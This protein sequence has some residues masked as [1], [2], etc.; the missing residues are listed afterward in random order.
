MNGSSDILLFTRPLFRYRAKVYL[1]LIALL[2]RNIVPWVNPDPKGSPGDFQAQNAP[3]RLLPAALGRWDE[4]TQPKLKMPYE[5]GPPT[6]VTEAL[7]QTLHGTVFTFF[8]ENTSYQTAWGV[9][10][11]TDF[12]HSPPYDNDV[13]ISQ[14]SIFAGGL[15][16]LLDS[17]TTPA[18]RYTSYFTLAVTVKSPIPYQTCLTRI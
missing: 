8:D 1:R 7:E 18:E 4:D 6:N 5:T 13:P 12:E 16:A 9:T 17:R 11:V 14:V 2:M 3:M 15:R 10:A